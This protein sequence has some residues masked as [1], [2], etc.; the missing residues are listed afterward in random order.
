MS[1]PAFRPL[2]SVA[3][4]V[5]GRGGLPRVPRGSAR[6]VTFLEI[7]VVLVVLGVLAAVTAPNFTGS[8]ERNKLKAATRELALLAKY[9]RQQAVLRNT[10][11]E[12]YVDVQ[13]HKYWLDLTPP[14]MPRRIRSSRRDRRGNMEADHFLDKRQGRIQFLSAT[15]AADEE[16]EPD[17]S[18]IQFHRNGS[19]SAATVVIVDQKERQMTVEI[20]GS[21]GGVRAYKGEPKERDVEPPKIESV[22]DDDPT[23]QPRHGRSRMRR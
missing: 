5:R 18:R 1:V 22:T 23:P 10:R 19:A 2:F 14:D 13:E 9:A 7:M 16:L 11:T 6:G 21:T 4:L 17:V 20:T 8:H 3:R 15:S 12:I